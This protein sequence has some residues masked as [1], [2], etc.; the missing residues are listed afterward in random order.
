MDQALPGD[1]LLYS[2]HVA[3]YM[4][5]NK[6]VHASNS[7]PYPKG[8]IKVSGPANYKPILKIVRYWK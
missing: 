7:A 3:I 5:N 4:G 2:G 6:V 8:G 1:L